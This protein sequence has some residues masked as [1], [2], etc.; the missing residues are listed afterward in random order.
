MHALAQPLLG[1]DALQQ[2]EQLPALR[3]VEPAKQVALGVA[4]DTFE[5]GH[6]DLPVA[7]E[8]QRMDSTVAPAAPTLDEAALF[9]I[10]EEHDH[11]AGGR[12]ELVGNGLLALARML[13]DGSKHADVRRGDA[14][15]CHLLRE[16]RSGMGAELGQQESR[17]DEG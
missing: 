4:A 11:P 7:G 1:R 13:G 9:E 6:E 16:P 17:T 12:T 3:D 10:V 14:E 15:R 8:V 2:L 5:L